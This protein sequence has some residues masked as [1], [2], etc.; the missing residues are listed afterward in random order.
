MVAH[1]TFRFVFVRK[2]D[3]ET[4][5]YFPKKAS[6]AVWGFRLDFYGVI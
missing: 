5:F 6:F 4:T 1:N 2:I 3:R